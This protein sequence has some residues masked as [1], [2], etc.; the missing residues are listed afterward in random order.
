[1][2]KIEGTIGVWLAGDGYGPEEIKRDGAKAINKLQFSNLDMSSHGWTRIGTAEV[3]LSLM[4]EDK[5]VESKVASMRAE[6][7]SIRATSENAITRLQ[8]K[9]QSLLAI[10]NEAGKP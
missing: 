9:I 10:T 6:I 1:M 4:S 2:K 7:Q 8:E 5:M 3:T